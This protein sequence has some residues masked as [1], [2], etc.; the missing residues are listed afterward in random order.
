MGGICFSDGGKSLYY[1]IQFAIQKNDFACVWWWIMMQL[2]SV[3]LMSKKNKMIKM[4]IIFQMKKL[5]TMLSKC[6][7]WFEVQEEIIQCRYFSNVKY[8]TLPLRKYEPKRTKDN[9]R[10][11]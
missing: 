6:T 11:F 3:W 8:A 1:S 7:D 9:E 5:E 4:C 10:L 2:F